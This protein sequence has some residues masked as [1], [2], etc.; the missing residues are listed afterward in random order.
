MK[1][2]KFRIRPRLPSV[3]RILKSIM[4]V[5]QLPSDIELSLPV[6]SEQFLA[7]VVPAAFYQT[8]SKDEVPA[9]FK[10]SLQAAGMTKAVAVTAA[11]GTIGP[12]AEEYLSQLLMNGQTVRSQI[13]TAFCE[14]G[15]DLAL[16]FL[17]RLLADDAKSDD[18]D[19]DESLMI[20][21]PALLAETLN[22]LES[23]QEGVA[24]DA[25]GHLSPRFT[26]VALTAWWPVS[27]KKRSAIAAKKKIA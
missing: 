10:P 3:G 21:D 24:L 12:E 1:V 9:C 11:V 18:C 15:A 2:K 16:Q 22:V 7:S 17:L 13:V 5:K 4:G 20:S 26:R 23:H 8:W 25:A 19:I 27:K 14:E 6:E